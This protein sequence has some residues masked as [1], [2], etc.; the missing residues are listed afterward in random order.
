M[1]LVLLAGEPFRGSIGC[2]GYSKQR[3][4]MR[5]EVLGGGVNRDAGPT[6]SGIITGNYD[7]AVSVC[8]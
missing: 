7:T 1:D 2:G 8:L 6:K 3:M 4:V 5:E